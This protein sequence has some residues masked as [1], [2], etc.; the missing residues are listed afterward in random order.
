MKVVPKCPNCGSTAQVYPVSVYEF[1]T[2]TNSHSF[3]QEAYKYR[4][5]CSCTFR[6]GMSGKIIVE[7]LE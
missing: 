3:L 5:G 6:L 2:N 7:V 4:C 1:I